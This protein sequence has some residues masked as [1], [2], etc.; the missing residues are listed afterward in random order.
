MDRLKV[1][2]AEPRMS[3]D[4][5]RSIRHA[6]V[7]R[8]RR[9]ESALPLANED[10]VGARDGDGP[11]GAE[12]VLA[13]ADKVRDEV[14]GFAR[15]S[16]ARREAEGSAPVHDLLASDL[17]ALRDE[18]RVAAARRESSVSHRPRCKLE[19]AY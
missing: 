5:L 17:A 1:D 3:L 10:R 8:C 4:H 16:R 12:S 14:L 6:I 18:R 19:E 2:P 9:K 7:V 13:L 15:D 11:A